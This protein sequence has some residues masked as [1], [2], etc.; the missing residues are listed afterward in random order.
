MR[1]LPGLMSQSMPDEVKKYVTDLVQKIKSYNADQK[2]TLLAKDLK[3][4][5]TFYNT[6]SDDIKKKI[7]PFSPD[8]ES[9]TVYEENWGPLSIEI[10]KRFTT[11]FKNLRTIRTLESDTLTTEGIDTTLLL[12]GGMVLA[13]IMFNGYPALNDTGMFSEEELHQKCEEFELGYKGDTMPVIVYSLG[14]IYPGRDGFLGGNK[15][16]KILFS[17]IGSIA[18]KNSQKTMVITRPATKKDDVEFNKVY[19][20]DWSEFNCAI[21]YWMTKNNMAYKI[22]DYRP[23]TVQCDKAMANLHAMPN[24]SGGRRKTKRAKKNKRRTRRTR[25]S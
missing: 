15:W 5:I 11:A 10:D 14:I 3:D 17:E 21:K 8:I 24:S 12:N 4:Y 25:R 22:S 20:A 19:A 1:A 7:V 13:D 18:L 23:S 6:L 16:K 9:G 2:R